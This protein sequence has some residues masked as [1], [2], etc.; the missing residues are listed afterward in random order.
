[1][2]GRPDPLDKPAFR[3]GLW[4][5]LRDAFLSPPRPLS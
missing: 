4:Q 1:M 2:S 5:E 3:P